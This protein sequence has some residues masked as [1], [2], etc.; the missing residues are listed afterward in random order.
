MQVAFVTGATGFLGTHLLHAL[1]ERGVAVHA[2]TRAN[3]TGR[4]R[5][6]VTWHFVEMTD[7]RSLRSAIAAVRPDVVFHLAAYGTTAAETDERQMYDVNVRGVYNLCEAISDV[8][9]SLVRMGSPAEYAPALGPIAETHP[10]R[11]ET[12]YGVSIHH[13]VTVGKAWAAAALRTHVVVRPFGPF[14][15]GDRP[16]RLIPFVIRR[17]LNGERVPLTAGEQLRDFVYVDDV[18]AAILAAGEAPIGATAVFNIGGGR[19]IR[20]R[21]AV[22]AIARAVGCRS[23]ALLDFGAVPYR[24][25]D[26]WPRYAEIA[27]AREALGYAPCI[28]FEDGVARTVAAACAG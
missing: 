25:D 19:P 28:G 14:G 4:R 15:P 27:E 12:P 1:T 23:A 7:V 18:I 13:A 5:S 10:C 17:L 24:P 26:L 22:E 6:E 11:P 20:V 16:E 3:A 2:A 21:A 9:C 8:D